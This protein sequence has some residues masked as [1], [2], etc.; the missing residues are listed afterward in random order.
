MYSL[1]NIHNYLFIAS[2]IYNT[3]IFYVYLFQE[4]YTI[5]DIMCFPWA[6]QIKTGYI[7]TSGNSANRFLSFEENYPHVNAWIDR[8]MARPA[9]QR[10]ITVCSWNDKN[11]KPW[12]KDAAA[13]EESK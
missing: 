11:P 8:I 2:R 6:R 13:A 1:V 4:E 12:L 9:V 10:G 5:A 7:H 3:N